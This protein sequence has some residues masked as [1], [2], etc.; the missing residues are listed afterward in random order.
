MASNAV[1]PRI[2]EASSLTRKLYNNWLTLFAVGSSILVIVPLFAIFA[3]LVM[4]GV[5]SINW[6]F[7]AQAT[8]PVGEPGGGMGNAIVGSGIILALASL[9]GIPLGIGAG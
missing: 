9:I 5:G 6:A 1:A 2:L 8:K 7:L 3:Y 4:K